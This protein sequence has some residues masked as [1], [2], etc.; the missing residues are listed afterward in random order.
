VTGIPTANPQT[1]T[2]TH[3][4]EKPW[5]W[6]NDGYWQGN[7]FYAHYFDRISHDYGYEPIGPFIHYPGTAGYQ[8][9]TTWV[10]GRSQYV[11]TY[12]TEST[13]R[14]PAQVDYHFNGH[15]WK[16]VSTNLQDNTVYCSIPVEELI[17]GENT[18][19]FK[20]SSSYTTSFEWSLFIPHAVASI[21]ET[22]S[23][24]TYDAYG[25]MLSVTDALGN[26]TSFGYDA[27]YHCYLISITNALNNS[28]TASYDHTRG[29]LT[30]VTDLK[31]N[32]I[33]YE[34]DILGRVTKKINS[35]LS[36]KEAVYDDQNNYTTVYD[37]LDHK[38]IKNNYRSGWR[39]IFLR[40]RCAGKNIETIL[41]RWNLYADS[42]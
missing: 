42:V 5:T 40:I 15:D 11:R 33:L 24:F 31:G 34:Y 1:K 37:E 27:Q 36:E 22:T 17:S 18:L 6:L 14:Y 23:S 3:S 13:D 20:E 16:M 28:V 2:E 39:Y 10:S 38:I 30:S 4:V 29:F 21:E 26:T 12:Y 9:Y 7:T 35:D 8:S 32:T 25:N 19:Y 41:P